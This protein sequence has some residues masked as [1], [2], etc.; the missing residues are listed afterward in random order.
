M[1]GTASDSSRNR[2]ALPLLDMQNKIGIL[3]LCSSCIFAFVGVSFANE[4]PTST[5]GIMTAF[6]GQRGSR[7]EWEGGVT[8]RRACPPARLSLPLFNQTQRSVLFPGSGGSQLI[9][10]VNITY[11]V[12][13]TCCLSQ[14][15]CERFRPRL[16]IATI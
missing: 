16:A 12:S 6:L 11:R 2:D 1:T 4:N 13:I 15:L 3:Q 8:L 5:G 14:A 10:L 7:I 9:D